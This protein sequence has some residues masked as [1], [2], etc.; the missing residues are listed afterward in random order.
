MSNRVPSRAAL[1]PRAIAA[2]LLALVAVSFTSRAAAQEAKGAAHSA[3]VADFLKS[4]GPFNLNAAAPNVLLAVNQF[5]CTVRSN[6]DTCADLNN[7]PV[8]PGGFWPVGTPNAYMFNSGVNLAGRIPVN[9][10]GNPWAGDTVGA[11]FF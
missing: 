3:Q 9:S 4:R 2:F 11:F 6:G 1:G 7:S 8:N 5:Q 10:P